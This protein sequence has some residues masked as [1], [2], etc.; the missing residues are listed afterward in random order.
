MKPG[1]FYHWL[2]DNWRVSSGEF[3]GARYSF[4][5]YP[6]L[7][8]VAKDSSPKMV[9]MKCAQLG[10]TE[11]MIARLFATADLLKGN[12][13]YVLP[14]DDLATTISR[15]RLK[16]AH[17]INPYLEKSLTGFDTLRQFK[18]KDSF[19][20][21]RGSQT[22]IRDG[23]E[24]QRQLIS[25][26]A[27]KLFG[28]E[29]D[30]WNQGVAGKLISR[31]GASLDPYEAYFTTPRIPD[32]EMAKQFANSDQKYWAIKCSHCN[33]WNV[34]LTLWDNV[35]NFEY[36]DQEHTFICSKCKGTLDRLESDS[37]KAQWVA[38]NPTNGRWSGYQFTKL[39]FRPANI[40]NIVDRFND[41]E[42]QTEC[43]NDDLGLP[44]QE[45]EFSVD[46]K[47]IKR[48]S[49][50]DK[51]TFDEFKD[52]A[53]ALTIGVDIGKVMHANVRGIVGDKQI[54]ND[55]IRFGDHE[56]LKS[57]IMENNIRT[58]VI[59]AQ[60]DFRASYA[61]CEEMSH[62]GDFRVA[63]Y[64]TWNIPG[65]EKWLVKEDSSSEFIITISRNYAMSKVMFELVSGELILPNDAEYMEDG[66]V[67]THLKAPKRIS[68]RDTRTGQTV[69]HFPPTRTPDHFYHSLVY[70]RCA[71]ELDGSPAVVST[72]GGML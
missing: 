48:N 56:E 8:D 52:N 70:S 17:A 37:K 11:L 47:L 24:Y 10:F 35:E 61:F 9:A 54:I 42:T 57:Y 34:P 23:R 43:Y 60:P 64:D 21:I 40:D 71:Q 36:P 38:K 6:F 22:Q 27:S 68:K 65:K 3:V 50:P 63:Y 2:L 49:A 53:V 29:M 44:H 15:A 13:M 26:D 31:I 1:W 14:T 7:I 5:H 66:E 16:N 67:K 12:L 59:D 45:K 30:E 58:G 28:D 62:W 72:G 41:P 4:E 20:Y 33:H 55:F 25:I 18:F 51:Q 39:F 19:I 32:G 46:D 69:M